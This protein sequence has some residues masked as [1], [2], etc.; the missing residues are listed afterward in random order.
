[1]PCPCNIVGLLQSNYQGIFSASINGSTTI[2]I[3]DEGTVLLGQTVSTLNIGAYAFLPG[4]DKFLGATCN[5]SAEAQIP[6][7]TKEDCA[8]NNVY[9]I[10]RSGARA[11]ITNG[12]SLNP[13]I[14]RLECSPGIISTSFDANASSGPASPYITGLRED[15]FKLVYDGNPI[16]VD[17]S[18]PIAYVI[19]LGFVGTITA[20]LQNF[21]LTVSPPDPARVSYSFVFAGTIN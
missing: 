11:S 12:A 14:I 4:Q 17:T 16:G 19:N 6:W 10:P 20:F 13:A 8:T 15:G 21:S 9:F 18:A 2:E 7:I 3:S 5:A 1:M